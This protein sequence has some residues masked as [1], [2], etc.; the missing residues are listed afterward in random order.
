M[1]LKP[2]E[3]EIGDVV[4]FV[5]SL[6]KCSNKEIRDKARTMRQNW[7]Q[8]VAPATADSATTPA[9]GN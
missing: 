1:N 4:K 3:F 6:R 9:G 2:S 8:I 5:A 7:I